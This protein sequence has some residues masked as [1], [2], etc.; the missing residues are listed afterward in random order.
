MDILQVIESSV[1]IFKSTYSWFFKSILTILKSSI[2]FFCIAILVIFFENIEFLRV[3]LVLA[4]IW[5]AFLIP[6]YFIR[7]IVLG[8]NISLTKLIQPSKKAF[9]FSIYFYLFLYLCGFVISYI[10]AAPNAFVSIIFFLLSCLLVPLSMLLPAAAVDRDLKSTWMILSGQTL[11]SIQ[12]FISTILVMAPLIFIARQ[13]GG[14]SFSEDKLLIFFTPIPILILS[15][16]LALWF[17]RLEV[18]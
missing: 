3:F 15:I 18:K 5:F 10:F 12:I 6:F 2:P 4:Y 13:M 1:E 11:T 9:I 14:E 7:L 17:H 8:E 16:H